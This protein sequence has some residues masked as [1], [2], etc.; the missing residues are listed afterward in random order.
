MEEVTSDMNILDYYILFLCL[1]ECHIP[2][3]MIIA[4]AVRIL[5]IIID[6]SVKTSMKPKDLFLIINTSCNNLD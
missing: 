4:I 5:N 3:S 2:E 6:I 1:S